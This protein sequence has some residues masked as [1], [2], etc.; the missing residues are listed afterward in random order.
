M[1]WN[2]RLVRI[3]VGS[4]LSVCGMVVVLPKV[5]GHLSLNGTA[6][7]QGFNERWEAPAAAAENKPSEGRLDLHKAVA[8]QASE[9]AT[10]PSSAE[11]PETT[12]RSSSHD[13]AAGDAARESKSA[14]E[15]RRVRAA[16]SRTL[17]RTHEL[18][19]TASQ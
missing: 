2:Q 1:L 3:T 15:A 6:P 11:E 4:L 13:A 16:V 8:P 7:A 14:A 19:R 12:G 10:P 18:F 9:K 5:P 17:R